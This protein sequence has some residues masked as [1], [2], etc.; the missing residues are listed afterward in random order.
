M[1]EFPVLQYGE[2]KKVKQLLPWPLFL[3][4]LLWSR[5]EAAQQRNY[6]V[7]FISMEEWTPT[8]ISPP[9]SPAS[10]SPGPPPGIK[11]RF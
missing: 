4:L 5:I 6:T 10:P 2:W 8:K 1:A 3:L 11:P 9:P 7:N